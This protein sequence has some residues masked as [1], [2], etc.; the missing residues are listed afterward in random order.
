MEE[1]YQGARD[2]QTEGQ[3]ERNYQQGE[4]VTTP[5]QPLWEEKPQESWRSFAIRNQDG[6]GTCVVQTYATELGIIFKQ[7]Y[8]RW[9]DFSS[10]YPYQQ[11]KYPTISGCTSEDIY[12]IFPKIG[13]LFER[14]MP[15]QLFTDQEVMAV[16]K[17]PYYEDIAKTFKITRVSLPLDFETVASTIQATGKGVMVWFHFSNAEW[18]NIPQVLPQPLPRDTR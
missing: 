2:T 6:S 18:T 3:K 4:F 13:N 14:D 17:E 7:K 8:N 9:I 1:N 5:T 16:N 15:S 10:S 12:S 11:R